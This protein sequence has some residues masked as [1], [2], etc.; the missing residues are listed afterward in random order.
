[1]EPDAGGQLGHRRLVHASHK[2]GHEVLVMARYFVLRD[3]MGG[4]GERKYAVAR[5]RE[6]ARSGRE[7]GQA[8]GR[9]ACCRTRRQACYAGSGCPGP[10]SGGQACS[11]GSGCSDSKTT[12]RHSGGKARADG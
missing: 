12:F 3:G 5:I 1:M 10:G 6:D 2:L 7:W 9:A 11:A 4:R 8:A